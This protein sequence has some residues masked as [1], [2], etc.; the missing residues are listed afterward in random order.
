MEKVKVEIDFKRVL[1]AITYTN[2][3]MKAFDMGDIITRNQYYQLKDNIVLWL[4]RH[5][6][7]QTTVDGMEYLIDKNG[8]RV[9]LVKLTIS[10]NG[11]KCLLHQN[12][13]DKIRKALKMG[14]GVLAATIYDPIKYDGLELDNGA[15]SKFTN[16]ISY[17]RRV[18]I[19]M[20]R[21]MMDLNAFESAY[22][23]NL[24]SGDPWMR[25]YRCFLPNNGK[26]GIKVVEL[27]H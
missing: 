6:F 10:Y 22:A 25:E 15:V 2:R 7:T 26:S 19:V 4:L 21:N 16:A 12:I 17:L 11:T 9:G 1:E 8:G 3:Y 27:N 20:M 13:N 23:Q 24:K 18:R 5:Q 14:K